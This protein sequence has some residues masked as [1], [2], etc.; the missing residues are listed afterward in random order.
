MLSNFLEM[1]SLPERCARSCGSSLLVIKLAKA[2][3]VWISDFRSSREEK[4]MRK[5]AVGE[6]VDGIVEHLYA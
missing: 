1:L 4:R 6:N 5:Y 3:K 2:S